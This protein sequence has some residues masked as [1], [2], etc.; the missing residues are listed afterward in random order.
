M[1]T[2]K[3]NYWADIY[4]TLGR[5]KRKYAFYL[6]DYD[7]SDYLKNKLSV[8]LPKPHVGWASRAVSIRAN[9]THFDCFENDSIGFNEIV[10]KYG[11]K[12]AFDKVKDDILICGCGFL[13]L[14]G[15]KIVPFTAEEATGTFKWSEQA[16]SDGLAVFKKCSHRNAFNYDRVPDSWLEFDGEKTIIHEKDIDPQVVENPTGRPLIGLLT[17]GS[18]TKRPFGRSVLSRPARDAILDASRTIRQA[19]VAAHYYNIKVNLILGVDSQTPV[20]T[21]EARVGDIL[22]VGTNDNGQIPQIAEFAQHGMAPFN[23]TILL[24]AQNFCAS[25]KLNLSNIAV[26]AEVPQSNE[27]LEI[28]GDDLKDDIQAWQSELGEQLKYFVTTLFMNEKQINKLDDNLSEKIR[29]IKPIWMPIYETDISRFGDGLAKI[30]D[31]KSEIVNI[32]SIWR[33][34]GLTSAEIDDVLKQGNISDSTFTSSGEQV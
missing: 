19:M 1:K 27:A 15:D 29:K 31:Q 11:L 7:Y 24:A 26:S 18:T 34:L 8:S 9:K 22:R 10:E 17:Y 5:S 3:N 4:S 23:D 14:V 13:A 16:L 12:E 6:G 33:T 20:D 30:A 32:R 28:V 2:R 25:T 21:I